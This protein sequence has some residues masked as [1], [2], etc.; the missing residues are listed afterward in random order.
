VRP[1]GSHLEGAAE[2]GDRPGLRGT[3]N[4]DH[5]PVGRRLQ[6]GPPGGGEGSTLRRGLDACRGAGAIGTEIPS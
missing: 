4:E 6:V 3:A 2:Q 1:Q 5:H